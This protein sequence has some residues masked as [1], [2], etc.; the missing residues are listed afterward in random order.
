MAPVETASLK[1]PPHNV[2]GESPPIVRPLDEWQLNDPNIIV[3]VR[4]AVAGLGDVILWQY[5]IVERKNVT[6]L[7]RH[8]QGLYGYNVVQVLF[9]DIFTI[10]WY[11]DRDS[12]YSAGPLAALLPRE[13]TDFR[14]ENHDAHAPR[15]PNLETALAQYRE[16]TAMEG[17]DHH[18]YEI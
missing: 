2:F 8:L 11:F 13:W 12:L 15:L 9:I 6:A 4:F 17:F 3:P 5:G 1:P 7:G 14:H 10:L 18:W 16:R